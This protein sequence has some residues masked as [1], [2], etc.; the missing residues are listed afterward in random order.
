MSVL[1]TEPSTEPQPKS[2]ETAASGSAVVWI[3][4]V[5][6]AALSLGLV[7]VVSW[8]VWQDRA[9]TGKIFP[10]VSV[11]GQPVGGLTPDAARERMYRHVDQELSKGLPFVAQGRR[12]VI[13]AAAGTAEDPRD[14]VLYDV[15]QAVDRAFA[16]GRSGSWPLRVRE[17]VR[18]RILG[19]DVAPQVDIDRALLS[20][21]VKDAFND[22][23]APAQDARFVYA[24]ETRAFAVLPAVSGRAVQLDVAMSRFEDAAASLPIEDTIVEIA[25][26]APA[27][28]ADDLLPILDEVGRR[29]Q[30][31]NLTISYNQTKSTVATSTLATWIVSRNVD[32]RPALDM[33]PKAVAAS[34]AKLFPEAEKDSHNGGIEVKDGRIVAFT[35][36]TEG[37]AIDGE[38]MAAQ[39]LAE[40]P[41]TSTFALVVKKTPPTLQGADPEAVGIVE[42]VGIGTSDYSGS[43][44]NRRKN[45][46][47]GIQ[48]V[49]GTVVRP[50]EEFSMMET[51][52]AIDGAHGWLPELVIKGNETKPEYGGGLCQIGTTAFRGALN[53]GLPI[54]ERRNHSYRVRY[55]E[56]AGTDATLYDPKP[57]FRFRNDMAHPVLIN[58]YSSGTKVVF[59]FWGTKD[60]RVADPIKPRIFNIVQPPPM[61]VIETTDLPP[62]QKKCT[63]SAHNG[64]TAEFTY[65]VTYPNGEV[66]SEVFRS[67][68][69]P[70]QAVCLVGKAAGSPETPAP[71][72]PTP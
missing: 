19:V 57:D 62:G 68:Y 51:L 63:E 65:T 42:Q 61:K 37:V 50:G 14:I 30:G 49:N 36:G 28:R 29:L 33:D 40:W 34:L 69:R 13:P 8:A 2:V 17:Q 6:V 60:G 16:Y 48:R 44:V 72:L 43:P 10:G 7:G 9:A 56:P 45:I 46:A 32:G 70:W 35:G 38:A 12:V 26:Q 66:K 25:E 67:H 58:A 15:D 53:V 54:V 39:F 41:A 18:L 21:A 27:V 1:S 64:A 52:G 31:P 24:T 71:T 23:D 3:G 59:E 5:L 47:L 11:F 4:W 22:L 55:Y 20:E